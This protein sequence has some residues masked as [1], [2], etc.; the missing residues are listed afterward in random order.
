MP[1][2]VSYRAWVYDR[3]EQT[4][5]LDLAADPSVD[6][7]LVTVRG[8]IDYSTQDRL[9]RYL[10]E[11]AAVLGPRVLVLD[12]TAVTF[13]GSAGLTVLLEAAE[14]AAR[15]S[16]AVHPLRVV[17][18]ESRHVIAP[19]QISGMQ[20]VIRLHHDLDEALRDDRPPDLR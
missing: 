20:A 4:A 17:V 18:D 14:D 13:F 7:V 12:L 6:H 5:T 10:R 3:D 16:T 8:D 19:L 15:L 11:S 2:S 1:P 9:R